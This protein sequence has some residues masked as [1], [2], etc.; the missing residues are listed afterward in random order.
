MT[1]QTGMRD[2]ITLHSFE[3]PTGTRG[4]R[5]R[6]SLRHVGERRQAG[7]RA[8]LMLHG[9]NTSSETFRHPRGGLAQFLKDRG[10]DVWLLDWRGSPLVTSE[11]LMRPPLGGS[12]EEECRLFSYDHVARED[13]PGAVAEVRARI[14]AD[15]PLSVLG[16][17]VG[18]GVVSIAVALGQLESVR[19]VVLTGLGLF[20]E[21]PWDGW[22]KVEDF[23]LERVQGSDP[24]R[25]GIS[26][27]EPERWPAE[28]KRA[29][30]F[31]PSAWK[32]K[33]DSSDDELLGR[34]TFMI[35]QPW[36]PGRIHP[37]LHGRVLREIFGSL[38][39]GLY[40]HSGQMVRRGYAAPTTALDVIDRPRVGS[41]RTRSCRLGAAPGVAVAGSPGVDHYF[42]PRPFRS[43]RVTLIT[44]AQNRVW[45]RDGVDL[46]YE[47]LRRI[48]GDLGAGQ[49]V[50]HV[51]PEYGLQDL[52]WHPNA[53]VDVYPLIHAGL[54]S[55]S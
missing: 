2:P 16:H 38:H 9:G 29:Y 31:W 39:L 22:A 41:R 32:I 10:W 13:L 21:A 14:G 28:M 37:D 53:H 35:G 40:L 55:G 1:S 30:D 51:L 5:I 20:Y 47:W 18:S 45:H 48:D 17:C 34:V 6:L 4:A 15:T 54:G 3:V 25:R 52:Y 26:P 19:N 36:A 7:E 27:L 44:G 43:K 42:I 33:G 50:K 49:Y 12:A 23:I 11:L 46:M 24:G 8:I